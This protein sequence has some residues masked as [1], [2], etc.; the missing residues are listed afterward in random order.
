MNNS[1]NKALQLTSQYAVSLRYTLYCPS[2]ELK[3]YVKFFMKIISPILIA[4][5]LQSCTSEDSATKTELEGTWA[6]CIPSTQ[7]FDFFGNVITVTSGPSQKVTTTYKGSTV[8]T[9]TE[10][11]SNTDCTNPTLTTGPEQE[12]IKIGDKFTSINGVLVTEIDFLTNDYKTIYLLQD[13]GNTLYYGK[14]CTLTNAQ[15]SNDRPLEINY[16]LPSYK[17][18]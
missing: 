11:H 15:C 9:L 13:D 5:A 7:T 10:A 3:L 18:N 17:V 12:S 2:T 16:D 1:S 4:F 8:S 14:Q 6:Q